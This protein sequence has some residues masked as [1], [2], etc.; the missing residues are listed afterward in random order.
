[1][2]ESKRV[3]IRVVR[4]SVACS[5]MKNFSVAFRRLRELKRFKFLAA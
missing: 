2:D 4:A 1:M 3:S 5:K